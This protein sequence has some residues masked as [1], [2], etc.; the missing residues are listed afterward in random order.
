MSFLKNIHFSLNSRIF[1]F[2][3]KQDFSNSMRNIYFLWNSTKQNFKNR[4]VLFHAKVCCFPESVEKIWYIFTQCSIS[5]AQM[6]YR[7]AVINS[8]KKQQHQYFHLR[9]AQGAIILKPIPVWHCLVRLVSL[10]CYGR[11]YFSLFQQ[12]QRLSLSTNFC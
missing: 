3:K 12:Y 2:F 7:F 5:L 1:I 6:R 8:V 10:K 11:A 4:H 9:M